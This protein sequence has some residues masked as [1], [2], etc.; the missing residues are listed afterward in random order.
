MVGLEGH[1]RSNPMVGMMWKD[2]VDWEN[3]EGKMTNFTKQLL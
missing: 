3:M 2:I 1:F